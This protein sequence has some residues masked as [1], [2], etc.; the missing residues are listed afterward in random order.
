MDDDLEENLNVFFAPNANLQE[1]VLNELVSMCRLFGLTPSELF[2]KWESYALK[3]GGVTSLQYKTVRDFRKDTEEALDRESRA[4]APQS[5][6]KH[7]TATPR[8]NTSS[9][10]LAMLDGIIGS[11]PA[12]TNS[13]KRKAAH[14]LQTPATKASKGSAFNSPSA[15][16]S[17]AFADRQNSG[18]VQ[19]T[20]NPHLPAAVPSTNPTT[21]P[22]VK[23]KANTELQKFGYRSMAMQLSSASEILDDRIDTFV[24][25][26]QAKA[27]LSEAVFGNPAAQNGAEIVA[28]GRIACDQANGKLNAAS[29]VLETSRR[30]G[31]GMRV[32]LKFVDGV[33]YDVFPGKIVALRGSNVSGEYF[34]VAEV[35][36]LPT[37]PPA[38]STPAEVEVHNERLAGAGSEAQPMSLQI[39]SGPYTS[40]DNLD[41]AALHAI[42]DKAAETR[43]DVLILTG[44]FLDLEHPV[45]AL[46][47]FEAHLPEDAKI[48][49]DRATVN[50]VFRILISSRL[51][52]L[53]QQHPTITIILVPSLR[54]AISKHVSFPQDRFPKTALG[55]PKQVQIVTNPITLSINE[56][57]FGITSQDVL[58][59]LRR[60]NIYKTPGGKVAEDMLARLCGHLIDQRHFLPVFPTTSLDSLARPAPVPGEVADIGGDERLGV[61]ASLDIEYLKLAEWLNVLPDVLIVPS[62][63]TPFAK[64]SPCSSSLLVNMAK[65]LLGRQWCAL[66][67][68]W[69][70]VEKERRR[71]LCSHEYPATTNHR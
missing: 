9:E 23:L 22:R 14:D 61:G 54:D 5:V 3:M 31:A 39:A 53:T 50:D 57:V 11:T 71:H 58:S 45:V 1:D 18:T 4:Q 28:V 59:E 35:L 8:A 29:T 40:D 34:T 65:Q 15:V 43:P 56:I 52:A 2:I 27:G 30:M 60:E 41:F 44:P 12:R 6:K 20:L 69:L 32:P 33:A 62:A 26:L 66:H 63:L 24:E 55:L 21:E 70:P 25:L 16:Q 10:G 67:K 46:G 51:A 17:T 68:S 64:V 36:Q 7:I 48:D 38:A 37:I 49:P 47:D 19:E 13:N 42:L